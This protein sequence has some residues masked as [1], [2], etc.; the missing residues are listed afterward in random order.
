MK[1]R[2]GWLIL[3][4]LMV[5]SLVLASCGPA[6]P[7]GGEVEE[8][9]GGVV[10]GEVASPEAGEGPAE[11]VV[12]EEEALEMLTIRLTKHDGTSVTKQEEKPQYGGTITVLHDN[13]TIGFD[14]IHTRQYTAIANMAVN[15]E[16]L[17][18][19]I[20]RGPRGTNETAW[21]YS[22]I[23]QWTNDPPGDSLPQQATDQRQGANCRGCGLFG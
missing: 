14:D 23:T 6:A 8:T 13:T 18:G 5:L 20:T 1:R 3:S 10:T 17:T 4:V 16:L 19:D 22:G 9:G 11:E 12:V 15:E 2:I 21:N 7:S